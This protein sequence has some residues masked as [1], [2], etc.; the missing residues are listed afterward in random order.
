MKRSSSDLYENRPVQKD[1][2]K[3]VE[4]VSKPPPAPAGGQPQRN[5]GG[6]GLSLL[7]PQELAAPSQATHETRA[8]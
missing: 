5:E 2:V 6:P 7:P 3:I 4:N 8:H 1:E